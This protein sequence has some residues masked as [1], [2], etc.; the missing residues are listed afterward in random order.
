[1]S[2]LPVF[3]ALVPRYRA[4]L[5]DPR[6]APAVRD[7][8]IRTSS[9]AKFRVRC[10]E[11]G[12]IVFKSTMA[13]GEDAVSLYDAVERI[14]RMERPDLHRACR[15]AGLSVRIVEMA[16]TVSGRIRAGERVLEQSDA[17]T[18]QHARFVL[19]HQMAHWIWDNDA[20]AEHDGAN[21]SGTCMGVPGAPGHNPRIDADDERFASRWAINLLMPAVTMRRL[22]AERIRGRL[23]TIDEMAA[24][25]EAT[26]AAVRVRLRT[27]DLT[28]RE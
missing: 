15:E 28:D 27:L 22:H 3:T 4:S 12:A 9:H 20:L 14:R 24:R 10:D 23:L 13:L 1:M 18:K 5:E 7:T 2:M 21:E 25:L 16:P 11:G 26:R 17:I 6:H 19:A 8:T